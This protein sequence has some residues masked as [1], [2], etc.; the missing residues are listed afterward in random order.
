MILLVSEKALLYMAF[1]TLN[2]AVLTLSH[3][4]AFLPT[5]TVLQGMLLTTGPHVTTIIV[6]LVPSS[7]YE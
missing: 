4:R 3:G 5:T 2:H 1:A 7:D 6:K